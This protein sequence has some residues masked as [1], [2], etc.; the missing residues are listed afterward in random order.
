MN[1]TKDR[2]QVDR[3]FLLLLKWVRLV[4]SLVTSIREQDGALKALPTLV[5][6]VAT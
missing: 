4:T 5:A 3:I 6:L 1:E 2:F